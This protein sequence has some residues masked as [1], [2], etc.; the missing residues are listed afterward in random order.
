MWG[1]HC[2]FS[3]K[4]IWIAIVL[5]HMVFFLFLCFLFCE[6]FFH[7]NLCRFYYFNIEL[8]RIY[9]CNF[10]SLKHYELLQCFPTWFFLWFFS[11]I[12]FVDFIFL[13]L[14]WLEF[15]FTV[16]YNSNPQC[17]PLLLLFLH[18][19][20]FFVYFF[21]FFPK[22]LSFFFQLSSFFFFFRLFFFLP[23]LSLLILVFKYWAS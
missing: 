4:T 23:K 1:K 5:P 14:S 18:F 12:I 21:F 2:S 16:D 7:N 9:L 20:L 11:K 3:H 8:V 10:F 22:L 13:I 6:D 17:I 15:T 19:F